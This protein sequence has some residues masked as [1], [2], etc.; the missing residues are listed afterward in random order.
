MWR[1]L[2]LSPSQTSW[3]AFPRDFVALAPALA[4]KRERK[5]LL[6]RKLKSD[7]IWIRI[8]F[9]KKVHTTNSAPTPR[10]GQAVPYA[11]A[12]PYH[13]G[14]NSRGQLNYGQPAS[15]VLTLILMR[16]AP[17]ST[18]KLWN[19]S[20]KVWRNAALTVM[21][22]SQWWSPWCEWTFNKQIILH[23]EKNNTFNRT[24]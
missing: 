12:Q 14:S 24:D 3:Q 10:N 4:T 21:F 8:K 15:G 23:M 1:S 13:T 18:A 7:V 16:I 6:V 22:A 2:C 20:P 11:F 19:K 17:T 9:S 5:H